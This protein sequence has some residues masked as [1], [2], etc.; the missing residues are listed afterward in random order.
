MADTLT[1][2]SKEANRI[3]ARKFTDA[4]IK[5]KNIVDSSFTN[6]CL[7]NFDEKVALAT[8][9]A[10]S[11]ATSKTAPTNK[12]PETIS[13]I[14][15]KMKMTPIINLNNSEVEECL[16]EHTREYITA[17]TYTK[18]TYAFVIYE[19]LSKS[20]L[21]AN[22]NFGVSYICKRTSEFDACYGKNISVCQPYISSII[23]NV[24]F[25]CA[26]PIRKITILDHN[27]MTIFSNSP[28]NTEYSINAV[29]PPQ[30]Q[31]MFDSDELVE[32]EFEW[33]RFREDDIRMC[34]CLERQDASQFAK[35]LLANSTEKI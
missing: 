23:R 8:L 3:A 34:K 5:Y 4:G 14:I 27:R 26:K 30:V 28:S 22:R 31:F 20:S 18:M 11:E 1:E 35:Y 19:L 15:H 24:T 17:D 10:T 13:D 6:N 29:L 16:Q 12:V 32:V 7:D 2:D 9:D 21:N 25:R 33:I